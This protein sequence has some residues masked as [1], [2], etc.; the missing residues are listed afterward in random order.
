MRN[1]LTILLGTVIVLLMTQTVL[2]EEVMTKEQLK[3]WIDKLPP[4]RKAAA[5]QLTE[6]EKE[7][8]R[9]GD[10]SVINKLQIII[11]QENAKKETVPIDFFG[12]VVDQFGE[13]IAGA[14]V[15]LSVRRWTVPPSPDRKHIIETDKT[16]LFQLK[17]EKGQFLYPKDISKDGYEYKRLEHPTAFQYSGS[18]LIGEQLFVADPENPVIFHLRKRGPVEYLVERKFGAKFY[19]NEDER[20]S[21]YPKPP[22]KVR[23][24]EDWLDSDGFERGKSKE[25][26]ERPV[27]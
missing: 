17:G 1:C 4:D 18:M 21:G 23:I 6:E 22:Y 19:L 8:W 2:A 27:P 26:M 3:K 25:N 10:P 16:G 7:K 15:E 24:L 9:Q 11:A 5:N 13:P 12:K 14:T 20:P